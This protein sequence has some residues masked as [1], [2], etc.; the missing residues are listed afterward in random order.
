MFEKVS[1]AAE[2]LATR[3]SR[4][5]FLG[6]LGKSALALAGA[7]GG[8]LAFSGRALA[9]RAPWAS[10]CPGRDKV[11]CF[12]GPSA[13]PYCQWLCPGATTYT[14]TTCSNKKCLLPASGCV[15]VNGCYCF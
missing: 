6:R 12:S 10:C 7:L 11:A 5:D 4:R 14:Y 9:Q 13:G 15:L 2:R 1:Q 3:V 8:V